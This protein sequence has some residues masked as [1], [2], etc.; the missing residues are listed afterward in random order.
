MKILALLLISSIAYGQTRCPEDMWSNAIIVHDQ[1]LEIQVDP[2]VA[3]RSIVIERKDT[4]KRETWIIMKKGT[5]TPI[6]TTP[7]LK[8]IQPF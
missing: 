5:T 6:P 3:Y 4:T 7:V 2:G 8:C 1:T